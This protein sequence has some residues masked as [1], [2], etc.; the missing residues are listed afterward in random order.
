MTKATNANSANEP[1]LV[2]S[3]LRCSGQGQIEGDTFKRQRLAVT[4]FAHGKNL[5][6][7]Q[8]FRD[9]GV[10]GTRDSAD[11]PSMQGMVL[12][13]VAQGVRTV[14]VE[15]SSRFARDLIVSEMIVAMFQR[16][17]VRVI[18]CATGRD[19]CDASDPMRVLV[20]QLLG[21]VDEFNKSDTVTKLMKARTRIRAS[22][23][24]CEGKKP[25]GFLAHESPILS[26]I[27]DDSKAGRSSRTITAS[28]NTDG[29]KTRAGGVWTFATVAKIIRR[30]PR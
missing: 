9:E 27:L 15:N 13:V 24:R 19:M 4:N 28:L 5:K 10:S 16:I 1:E 7:V 14:L 21:S 25:Y 8:E 20:R 29:V 11:R 30:H 26:R 12:A 6:I 22:G 18:D 17:G 3:Y 2:F 23:K